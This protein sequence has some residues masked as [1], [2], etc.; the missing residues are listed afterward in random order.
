MNPG[1]QNSC[2]EA[3]R[4]VSNLNF[5]PPPTHNSYNFE[6]LS[7]YLR[8]MTNVP[9]KVLLLLGCLSKHISLSSY[10]TSIPDYPNPFKKL[11]R[12]FKKCLCFS[13]T[14]LCC[15]QQQYLQN[16]S[17]GCMLLKRP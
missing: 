4:C 9:L 2:Y 14:P 6:L 16:M 3:E 17:N 12:N 13:F 7:Y 10:L 15:N 11:R 1:L 8:D 5:F